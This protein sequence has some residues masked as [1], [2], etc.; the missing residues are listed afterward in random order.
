M[1]QSVVSCL[2]NHICYLLFGDGGANLHG[3]AGLGIDFATHLTRREGGAVYSITARSSTQHND[4][5]ARLYLPRMTAVGQD[6]QAATEHQRVAEVSLV[7][8]DRAID[9][10]YTHLI[11]VVTHAIDYA[12]GNAPRR[13]D[14]GWQLVDRRIRWTKAENVGTGDRL[15]GDAQHVADDA[16]HTCIC[17]TERLYGRGMVMCFNLKSDILRPGKTDDARIIAESGYQPGLLYLLRGAHEILFEQAVDGFCRKDLAAAIQFAVRN[18]G[19]E[20]FVR[21]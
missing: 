9:R 17:S 5:I 13:E 20:G 8:E 15:R 10:R 4:A 2:D 6:T 3:A 16:T 18:G 7:I 14:A 19:L 11:A 21:T 1:I 12:T